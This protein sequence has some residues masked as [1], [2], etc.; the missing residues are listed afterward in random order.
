MRS[1]YLGLGL[2]T[3]AF[4]LVIIGCLDWIEAEAEVSNESETV[5]VDVTEAGKGEA[6]SSVVYVLLSY[7]KERLPIG[8]GS[9][10]AVHPGLLSSKAVDTVGE[11][12]LTE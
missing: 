3:L 11:I 7:D 5:V 8:T 1:T 2:E 9:K 6:I 12:E 10:P 4:D